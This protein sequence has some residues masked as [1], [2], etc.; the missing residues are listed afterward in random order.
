MKIQEHD[1]GIKIIERPILIP[2]LRDK[3]C[4]V[5]NLHRVSISRSALNEV[6]LA[7]SYRD[8]R[9]QDVRSKDHIGQVPISH[10]SSLRELLCHMC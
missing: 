9:S 6:E 2:S 1:R 5:G 4:F 3:S 10:G 8:V 7:A